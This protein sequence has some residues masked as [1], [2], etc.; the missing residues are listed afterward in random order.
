MFMLPIWLSGA[1]SS[2]ELSGLTHLRFHITSMFSFEIV[3]SGE[4]HPVFLFHDLLEKITII[5][6]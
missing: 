3:A 4:Y 6:I 2:S 5:L 1:S